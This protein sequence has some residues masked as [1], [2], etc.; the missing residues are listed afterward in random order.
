MRFGGV[1][2]TFSSMSSSVYSLV[3]PGPSANAVLSVYEEAFG[4][5]DRIRP[6][7]RTLM[8]HRELGIHDWRRRR[9]ALPG[10]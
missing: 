6:E 10:R 7:S 9:S 2:V 1:A 4:Y 8:S 3:R 5:W